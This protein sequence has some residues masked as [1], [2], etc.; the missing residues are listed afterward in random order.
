[1]NR[2]LRNS[3]L[4]LLRKL[5]N[6]DYL[7]HQLDLY[8]QAEEEKLAESQKALK[9]KQEQ[10]KAEEMRILRGEEEVNENMLEEQILREE[11]LNSRAQS[12]GGPKSNITSSGFSKSGNQYDNFKKTG[13][14]PKKQGQVYGNLNGPDEEDEEESSGMEEGLQ[15]GEE[16]SLG[17]NLEEEEEEEE[18]SDGN[19]SENDF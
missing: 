14:D 10:M 5:R 12:R 11:T 7:E 4:S 1:M 15:S 19:G 13:M 8:N 3:T 17:D 6:L 16:E 18:R 9:R 2:N